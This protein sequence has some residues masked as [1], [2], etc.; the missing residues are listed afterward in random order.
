MVFGSSERIEE[1]VD[2]AKRIMALGYEEV[3]VVEGGPRE[4]VDNVNIILPF[5]LLI[6]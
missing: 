5:F 4:F 1:V 6:I 3:S 2:V